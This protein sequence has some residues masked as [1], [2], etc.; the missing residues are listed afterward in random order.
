[1]DTDQVEQPEPAVEL[2][3][4]DTSEDIFKN[5][6]LMH[7]VKSGKHSPVLTPNSMTKIENL[8]KHYHFDNPVMYY[9][10]NVD[11]PKFPYIMP[12]N[13]TV[14]QQIICGAHALGHFQSKS[15]LDRIKERYYWPD[16][17]A[18]VKE[19]IENAIH[20]SDTK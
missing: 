12:P 5:K 8:A 14:R 11:T 3:E 16:L 9:R 13:E 2:K 10:I 6:H 1:M 18:Q 4:D 19:H 15:T 17:A 7:F 20:A